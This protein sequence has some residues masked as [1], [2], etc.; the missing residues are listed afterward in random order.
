MSVNWNILNLAGGATRSSGSLSYAWLSDGTKV[1]TRA[2]DGSGHGVQKRYLGSFVYSNNTDLST[3]RPTEVESIAWDEGR[4]FFDLSAAVEEVAEPGV[5]DPDRVPEMQEFP[6]E[7]IDSVDVDVLGLYR[8]CLFATDHLGNVRTV[9]DITTDLV[10]PSIMEQNNYLPFGTLLPRTDPVYDFGNRWRYA[11]KEEQRFGPADLGLLDFG[12]RMYDP[13][14]ARWPSPDPMAAKYPGHSPFNYCE[15]SP[16]NRID[17]Q[18]DT[19]VVLYA[20]SGAYGLGHMAI[21]VQDKDGVYHLFSK[22][23]VKRKD[24]GTLKRDANDDLDVIISDV[25]SFLNNLDSNKSNQ[26]EGSEDP[27]YTHGFMIATTSEQDATIAE[28]MK[29][30]IAKDYNFFFS[31]CGEAVINSLKAGKVSTSNTILDIMSPL[32]QGPISG[33][34]NKTLDYMVPLKSFVNIILGNPGGKMYRP[35]KNKKN[36]K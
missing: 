15:G 21:L 24:D 23:G 31:N 2:D 25:Q 18:G 20:R 17:P 32:M 12:A 19:I 7:P 8:D 36:E 10:S 6:D 5:I 1:S 29:Q 35:Q 16:I 13:F 3:D 34:V 33:A 14:T 4:L 9:I 22:N 26:K 28:T 11:A 30:E 27:Y